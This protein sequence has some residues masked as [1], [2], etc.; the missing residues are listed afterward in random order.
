[1]EI[2]PVLNNGI[3]AINGGVTQAEKIKE[4]EELESKSVNNAPQDSLML[5]K[6]P[7]LKP[8]IEY[9]NSNDGENIEPNALA[10]ES[11]SRG[12]ADAIGGQAAVDE[13]TKDIMKSIAISSYEASVEEMDMPQNQVPQSNGDNFHDTDLIGG[14]GKGGITVNNININIDQ[15][16][17]LKSDGIK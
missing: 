5:N 2:N 14:E 3:N 15:E 7:T 11:M 6:E 1:M 16:Q 13:R 4:V 10:L 12:E 9:P 8:T 17:R